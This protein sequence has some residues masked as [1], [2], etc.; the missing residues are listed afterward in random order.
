MP[1]DVTVPSGD[2]ASGTT[3]APAAT[4]VPVVAPTRAENLVPQSVVD[5]ITADKWE[6]KRAQEE[7]ERKL[8]LAN[9]T[10]E[11]LRKI[12]A[13]EPP[14]AGTTTTT[15][16]TAPA[17]RLSADE[18]RRLV[19]EQSAVD[20]FNEACNKS[21]EEGRKTHDDF[22]RVVLQDLTRLSPIYDPRAGGPIIPQP[23]VEA[24]LETGEAHEVLYALGKDPQ[25]AERIMRLKPIQQAV[26]IAK[27]HD[28]L[29][30][31]R[32]AAPVA[33]EDDE[34]ETATPP[35]SRAPA[36]IRPR[37]GSG[38]GSA[39]PAFDVNDPSKSTTAE[40]IRQREA[41][42]ARRRASGTRH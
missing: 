40:W 37:T 31:G 11:E 1:D 33:G 27:F 34:G 22:D 26:E 39:R 9:A 23:L 36:P 17:P 24:A 21:V 3:P 16:P 4:S 42:I 32:V 28:K 19:S 13:G 41:E 8:A 38:S 5:R 15:T 10:V 25:N 2:G 30:A 29:V 6:A 20:R 12:A 18:L 35:T 7:A 14:N